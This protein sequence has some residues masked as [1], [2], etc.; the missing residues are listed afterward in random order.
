METESF[1]VQKQTGLNSATVAIC[2]TASQNRSCVKYR[3]LNW[4]V[5]YTMKTLEVRKAPQP[6]PHLPKS[7]QQSRTHISPKHK[8]Q[9]KKTKKKTKQN[10]KKKRKT[11]KA[12]G[13]WLYDVSEHVCGSKIN[14]LLVIT[15]DV[16]ITPPGRWEGARSPH[17]SVPRVP[18]VESAIRPPALLADDRAVNEA[19]W[20]RLRPELAGQVGG[21]LQ[22]GVLWGALAI[23][24]AIGTAVW[25]TVPLFF[26]LLLGQVHGRATLGG[27]A[28]CRWTLL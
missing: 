27:T 26:R 7:S 22:L 24:R 14:H 19:A 23:W 25:S 15:C 9:S 2:S 3:H 21:L 18:R 13:F 8:S 4:Q 20:Q 28:G 16:L 10:K 11:Y 6:P 1:T 12:D 17:L 5:Q